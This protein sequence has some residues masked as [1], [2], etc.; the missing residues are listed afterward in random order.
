MRLRRIG[1]QGKCPEAR[2]EARNQ[3][4]ERLQAEGRWDEFV[5]LRGRLVK[6]H[7]RR[8]LRDSGLREAATA[9]ALCSPFGY[10]FRRY[11]QSWLSTEK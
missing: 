3:L 2:A 4:R 11:S 5:D 6:E 8:A 7:L 1:C 9:A 10:A